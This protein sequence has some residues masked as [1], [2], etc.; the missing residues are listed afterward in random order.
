MNTPTATTRY[1]NHRF[2]VRL[3][4]TPSGCTS[5]ARQHS[6]SLS[7]SSSSAPPLTSQARNSLSTEK[8]K[9]ASVS[10]K[11]NTSLPIT[12]SAHRVCRLPIRQMLVDCRMVTRAHRH[13]G[14]PSAPSLAKRITKSSSRMIVPIRSCS[15]RH[16]ENLSSYLSALHGHWL[17]QVD[18]T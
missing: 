16:E 14:N 5:D 1:K 17:R 13:G 18:N 9:P 7:K 6:S 12:T 2:P 10:S 15:F 11:L 4:A 8:S 3:L